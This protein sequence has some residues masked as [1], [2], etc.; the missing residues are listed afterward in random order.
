MPQPWWPSDYS[1][2]LLLFVELSILYDIHYAGQNHSCALTLQ[3]PFMLMRCFQALYHETQTD[4][5][6]QWPKCLNACILYDIYRSGN[7]QGECRG[8]TAFC[9]AV[10]PRIQGCNAGPHLLTS[11]LC[12]YR[13]SCGLEIVVRRKSLNII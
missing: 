11:S 12:P 5:L 10:G 9:L 7:E 8:A 6:F 13:G 3:I 1:A 4:P 2:N